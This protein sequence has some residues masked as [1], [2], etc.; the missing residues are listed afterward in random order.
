MCVPKQLRDEH[1]LK[2]GYRFN[3]KYSQDKKEVYLDLV[4]V[5]GNFKLRSNGNIDLPYKLV[6]KN[7]LNKVKMLLILAKMEALQ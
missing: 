3:I 7:L 2:Y 4:D 6:E 1:D 5:G